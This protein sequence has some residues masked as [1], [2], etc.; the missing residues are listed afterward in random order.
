M[1]SPQIP[2]FSTLPCGL[3]SKHP[4]L[5]FPVLPV[6]HVS[7]SHVSCVLFM[8]DWLGT[9]LCPISLDTSSSHTTHTTTDGHTA[10]HRVFLFSEKECSGDQWGPVGIY[11]PQ[12]S[13]GYL[14]VS[15]TD[16]Y[17]RRH[18]P[19]A[20]IC[21][22]SDIPESVRLAVAVNALGGAVGPTSPRLKKTREFW[23]SP[24]CH[25]FGNI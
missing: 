12:S 4:R 8:I 24:F 19:Y 25:K 20:V 7:R 2:A 14:L 1:R 11:T 13:K 15:H 22:K 16:N 23:R 6:I 3:I 9:Y 5:D 17:R 18:K 10:C 21:I